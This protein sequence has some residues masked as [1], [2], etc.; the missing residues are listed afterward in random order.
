MRWTARWFRWHRWLGWLVALQV[1]AWVIGG[2]LFAWLPFKAWV[3]GD[4]A[5]HKPA[6]VLP[7]DWAQRLAANV[8]E[9]AAVLAEVNS[10]Q[11]LATA[12]GPALR[13]RGKDA[14]GAAAERWLAATGGALPVPGAADIERFARAHYRGS[15]SLIDVQAVTAVPTRLALVREAVVPAGGSL[16]RVRFDDTL[17][18][19]LYFG[20]GAG[21]LVAVRNEA[22]VLYDF[23]WRLH[24]MDYGEGEDFNH[25]LIRAAVLAALLLVLTGSALSLL[26]LRRG[27]RARRSR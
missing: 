26:A 4:E 3:K 13:L 1:L 18:T 22:W 14:A 24:V 7:A 10:V 2:A 17:G 25:P 16:W 27:L 21:E 12:S 15:G 6:L 19:R 9:G 20:A 23:F 8:A 5:V 11:A